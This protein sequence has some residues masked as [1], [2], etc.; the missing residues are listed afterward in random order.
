MPEVSE[1]DLNP[2]LATAAGCVAVDWRVVVSEN[3][4]PAGPGNRPG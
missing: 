3:M 1:L 4:A 2:V